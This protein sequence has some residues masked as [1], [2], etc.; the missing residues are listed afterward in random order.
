M[1]AIA[2]ICQLDGAPADPAHLAAMLDA[3]AHRGPD[4]RGELCLGSIALGHALLATTPESRGEEQPHAQG[5]L[6]IVMDGR[7]DNRGE[8]ESALA[9]EAAPSPRT[10]AAIVLAAYEKWGESSF[11]RVLGDFALAIW[12]ARARVLV[13]ARD[14]LAVKPFYYWS[15][16]R[17]FVFASEPQAVFSHPAVTREPNEG[18]VAE[19]LAGS[20]RCHDETLF[21]GILRLPAAHAIVVGRGRARPERYWSLDPSRRARHRSDREHAEHLRSVFGEA[22]RC[23]LRAH[24]RVGAE[25]SG[26]LDSS[27]V[28]GMVRHLEDRGSAPGLGFETFSLV[29]PGDPS[30]DESEFVREV[31]ARWSLRSNCVAPGDAPLSRFAELARRYLVFPGYP[32]GLMSD[33][34]DRLAREKGFRVLLTGTGGDEG[35]TGSDFIYA[36]LLRDLRVADLIRQL[37]SDRRRAAFFR[38]A[39]SPLVQNGLRP[40]VPGFL[41]RA[42]RSIRP[43]RAPIPSWV[44]REF[45]E[46]FRLGDRF[47]PRDDEPRFESF[48]QRDVFLLYA[49]PYRS[50]AMEV[51]ERDAA[52]SGLEARHPFLD[53]RVVE[54]ALALPEEQRQRG[55]LTK[56]VLR[57]AMD[58]LLPERVHGRRGKTLFTPV[59]QAPVLSPACEELLLAPRI[60]ERGWIDPAAA[61]ILREEVVRSIRTGHDPSDGE[62]LWQLWMLV[63]VELWYRAAFEARNP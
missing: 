48:A 12:D 20:L 39:V 26:G 32:N 42:V 17:R 38:P 6:T 24:G 9:L 1:S 59:F 8:L 60:G 51:E 44:G 16:E 46:R 30:C 58:G 52:W 53:R 7:V 63:G 45:V 25:L 29:F 34:L 31:V 36:D 2:G 49:A 47:S 55:V 13:C 23:R 27:S 15:D 54:L 37:R 43:R 5:G 41:R 10:D 56:F 62:R 57:Q 14:P 22:V 3:L 50:E 40:L 35:F 28:V 33:P 19:Y 61:R 21:R 18:M 11:A 4:G